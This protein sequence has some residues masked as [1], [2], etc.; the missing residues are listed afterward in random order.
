MKSKFVV[1]VALVIAMTAAACGGDDSDS[2]G[3]DGGVGSGGSDGSAAA[4]LFE[5]DFSSACNGVA[6]EGAQGYQEG[7]AVTHVVGFVGEGNDYS[8]RST[9]LAESLR[10]AF[11]QLDQVQLVVCL[12]RTAQVEGQLCP[13]YEDEG[14]E[15][16]VQTFGATYDVTVRDAATGAE[17]EATTLEAPA[18]DCPFI[19]SYREGDPSPVPDY[20]TPDGDL[21]VLLAPYA[22]GGGG[23]TDTEPVDAGGD[24][25][26]GSDDGGS[27]EESG[28]GGAGSTAPGRDE[29]VSQLVDFGGYTEE[30]AACVVDGTIAEYG[31]F[32]LEPTDE[33]QAV[34]GQLLIDCAAEFGTTGGGATDL[35]DGPSTPA[36]GTDA[37]L[38]DLWNACAGGDAEACDSLYLQSPVGSDYEQFGFTCGYRTE[39]I[40]V[41]T[42]FMAG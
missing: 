5:S 21:E 22:A 36:P 26:A 13:G 1:A 38:D 17:L 12:S 30:E 28:D 9:M 31:E 11:D 14:L 42:D 41:C 37:A 32:V 16:E 10:A 33:Q 27:A 18:D 23:A 20:A 15:W 34:L 24:D 35:G 3:D 25:G 29:A 19:S 39:D 40:V 4:V 2:G 8:V 6:V 7:E